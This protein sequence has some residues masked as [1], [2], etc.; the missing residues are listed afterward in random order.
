MGGAESQIGEH[1]ADWDAGLDLCALSLNGK[2]PSGP[3][4]GPLGRIRT[5]VNSYTSAVSRVF[6]FDSTK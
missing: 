4:F 6:W 3:V 2:L 5:T 1:L